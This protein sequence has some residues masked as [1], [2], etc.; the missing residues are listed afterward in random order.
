M[1][2]SGVLFLPLIFFCGGKPWTL[3]RMGD[4]L[5]LMG[6][7]ERLSLARSMMELLDFALWG[8]IYFLYLR[9]ER[10]REYLPV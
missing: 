1:E 4:L 10:L 2:I 7:L 9:V 5:L 3:L 8:S 6:S